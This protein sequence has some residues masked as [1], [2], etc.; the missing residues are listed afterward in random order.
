MSSFLDSFVEWASWSMDQNDEAIEYLHSRGCS[1]DQIVRHRIGYVRSP[2]E[3]DVSF[4]KYHDDRC[5]TKPCDA[6]KFNHWSSQKNSDVVGSRLV[7]SIVLP[8]TSYAGNVVGCQLRSIRGKVYDTYLLQRRPEAYFFGLG[9]NVDR[10][11]KSGICWIVEG[12]FDQIVIERITNQPAVALTTNVPSTTQF[13]FLRRFC[14]TIYICL[15]NDAAGRK[16]V[17]R[18]ISKLGVE[19]NIIDVRL[20]HIEN[21][22]DPGDYWKILGD[23]G[24]SSLVRKVTGHGT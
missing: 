20:P 13:T 5:S 6:C 10:V 17:H 11:W 16:G 1:D 3:V 15:D 4:D 14:H 19:Y 12:P 21:A 24:L 23:S 9:P 7:G 8:I 18:I 2:Y 22:K